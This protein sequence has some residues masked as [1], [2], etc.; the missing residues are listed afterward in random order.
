MTATNALRK[1]LGVTS[2]TIF[3]PGPQQPFEIVGGP[4]AYRTADGDQQR[5]HE[6]WDPAERPVRASSRPC[7]LRS[8]VPAFALARGASFTHPR[9]ACEAFPPAWSGASRAAWPHP[10]RCRCI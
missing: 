7:R 2:F 1:S 5:T 10:R 4:A 6:T 8:G 3:V 9:H